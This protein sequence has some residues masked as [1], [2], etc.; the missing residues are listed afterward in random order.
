MKER[1][2]FTFDKETIELLDFLVDFGHFRN[3]SHAVEEAIKK[4]AKES[5]EF[6]DKTKENE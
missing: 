1:T 4:L 6:A 3:K 2:S 5:M